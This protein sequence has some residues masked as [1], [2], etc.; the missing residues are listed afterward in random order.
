MNKKAIILL[1][2]FI[3]LFTF[4]NKNDKEKIKLDVKVTLN[5]NGKVEVSGLKGDL[6]ELEKEINTALENVTVQLDGNKKK[7]EVHIK[8]EIKTK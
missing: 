5:K 7:H 1:I 4:A 2:A 3:P 8:A 6:K